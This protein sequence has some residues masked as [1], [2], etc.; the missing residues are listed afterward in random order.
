MS[1]LSGALIRFV[2]LNEHLG[3]F[4]W[5]KMARGETEPCAGFKHL[6]QEQKCARETGGAGCASF[7]VTL[8][9][10]HPHSAPPV[11]PPH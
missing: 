8:A 1:D 2:G 3:V 5:L 9:P 6:K 10:P 4:K 7:I 11:L